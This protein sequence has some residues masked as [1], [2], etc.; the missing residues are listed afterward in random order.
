MH[1][2]LNKLSFY[3]D[4]HKLKVKMQDEQMYIASCYTYRALSTAFHN[5]SLGFDTKHSH[6][7]MDYLDKPFMAQ[8][9][10]KDL[11]DMTEEELNKEIEK[12]IMAEEMWIASEKTRGLPS[13]DF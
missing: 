5:F 13:A 1:L 7:P 3:D 8:N 12:A 4:A 6:K 11:D 2:T 9:I 10:K